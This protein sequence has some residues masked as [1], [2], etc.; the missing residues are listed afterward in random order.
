M[1]N[2]HEDEIVEVKEKHSEERT[3]LK[4]QYE[5]YLKEQ[6]TIKSE[7]R[8]LEIERDVAREAMEDA[9]I[10]KKL[11]KSKLEEKIK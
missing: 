3:K 6:E 5:E 10:K 8:K 4:N 2:N 9:K 1:E 7:K 11:M